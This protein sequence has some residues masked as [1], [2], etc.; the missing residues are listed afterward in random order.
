MQ[1]LRF[2]GLT[3]MPRLDGPRL[4][5]QYLSVFELMSDGHFRTLRQIAEL[6][7]CPESSVSA[8]LRDMRKPRNGRHTV[9]R[10]YAG[11]GLWY[12]RLILNRGK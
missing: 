10:E 8:R 1:Q 11:E 6:T 5:K 7:R 9:E 3:Y 2:D 4:A 12:Y